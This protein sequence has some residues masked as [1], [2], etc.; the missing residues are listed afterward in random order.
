MSDSES[1]FIPMLTEMNTA[2]VDPIVNP[3]P[4][5]CGHGLAFH[6]PVCTASVAHSCSPQKAHC[7]DQATH[8]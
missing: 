1:S 8:V 6:N 5:S 7:A 4:F 3:L 2:H